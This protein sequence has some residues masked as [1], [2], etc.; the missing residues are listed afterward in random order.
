MTSSGTERRAGRPRVAAHDGAI[1]DAALRLL[2]TA[3]YGGMTID[4]VAAEAGVSKA[5]VYLRWPT[6]ADLATA[7]LAHVRETGGT[8]VTGDLRRDL[9]AILGAMRRN[10]RRLSATGI[11]GMCLAEERAAPELLA[12]FRERS[13]APR[14]AELRALLDAAR[15]RGELRDGAD[16]DTAVDL[17]MGAHHARYMAGGPF[18]RGWEERVV[19]GVLDGLLPTA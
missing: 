4:A 5:T 16:L 3:G 12:L 19:S 1:L 9:A 11:I 15:D 2:A 10:I 13:I 7:A 14:R 18:P 6:K 8:R 17:L